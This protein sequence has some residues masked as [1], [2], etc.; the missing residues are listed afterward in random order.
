[1]KILVF[2]RMKIEYGPMDSTSSLAIFSDDLLLPQE[3]LSVKN[4]DFFGP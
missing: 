4:F 1:M 2:V 3:I